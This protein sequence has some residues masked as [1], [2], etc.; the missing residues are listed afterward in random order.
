MNEFKFGKS[1]RQLRNFLLQPITQI[2][3]GL[4]AIVMSLVFSAVMGAITFTHLSRFAEVVTQ[5]TDVED[6]VAQLFKIAVADT[7]WWLV[8]TLVLYVLAM[9]VMS[10]IYTHRL[11]GP[12]IAFRRHINA[13]MEGNFNVRTILRRYDA[14][15]EVASD[16]NKLSEK[17]EEKSKAQ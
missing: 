8:L 3:L 9:M 7:K 1:R 15:H 6:E 12:T 10:I 11:V 14:F 13:L 4:Y 2:R 16:L 5:L 17:L